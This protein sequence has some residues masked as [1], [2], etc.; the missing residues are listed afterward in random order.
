[1]G[2]RIAMIA[3]IVLNVYWALELTSQMKLIIS[4]AML[5]TLLTTWVGRF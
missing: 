4:G 5:P 3:S 2:L 1:M